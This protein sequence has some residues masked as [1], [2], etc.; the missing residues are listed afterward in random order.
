MVSSIFKEEAISD[1][2][3]GRNFHLNVGHEAAMLSRFDD[4]IKAYRQALVYDPTSPEPHFQL[5]SLLEQQG[6]VEESIAESLKGL[7][8]AKE[9]HRHNPHRNAMVVS[10]ALANE[11]SR[12]GRCH[13]VLKKYLEAHLYFRES[14]VRYDSLNA[15]EALEHLQST[16]FKFEVRRTDTTPLEKDSKFKNYSRDLPF[17]VRETPNGRA[18]FATKSFLAGDILFKESSLACAPDLDNQPHSMCFNCLRTLEE[19]EFGFASSQFEANAGVLEAEQLDGLR[20]EI[21][22][23]LEIPK[24]KVR[25]D[26]HGH[27]YC[28]DEC[29][30]EAQRVLAPV[31]N[32]LSPN[33]PEMRMLF[34]SDTASENFNVEE[35]EK[36]GQAIMLKEL[37]TIEMMTRL[38]ATLRDSPGDMEHVDRLV[39]PVFEPQPLLLEHQKLQ[40]ETLRNLFP[41]FRD[42]LLTEAGYYRLKGIIELNTFT[43]ETHALKINLGEATAPDSDLPDEADPEGATQLGLHILMRDDVQIKGHALYRLGSFMNHSCEPNIGMPQPSFS[44][45]AAWVALRDIAIGEELVDSYV[46]LEEGEKHDRDLRRQILYENYHFWC[47][48]KLCASGK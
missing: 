23:T 14:L 15:R 1:E 45:K 22:T 42:S 35:A 20:N 17:L 31:L 46:A 6:H 16:H 39:Y 4:A 5:A 44:S 41:E 13:L 47:N 18:L 9:L 25:S 43:T 28:G 38:L 2:E 29:Y 30:H 48:C 33:S 34:P 3:R 40:L 11:F 36:E 21:L 7:E 24:L 32:V 12:L 8:L 10:L 19:T 37:S 26:S 27:K